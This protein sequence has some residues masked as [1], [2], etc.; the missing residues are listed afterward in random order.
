MV[1]EGVVYGSCGICYEEI[2]VS[3]T[4]GPTVTI[5]GEKVQILLEPDYTDAWAHTWTHEED[6]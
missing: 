5:D 6:G 3:V 4:F 2:P 1:T